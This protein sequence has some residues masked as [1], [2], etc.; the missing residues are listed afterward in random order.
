MEIE[1][2]E[3]NTLTLNTLRE[4]EAHMLNDPAGIFVNIYIADNGN[5]LIV[6]KTATSFRCLFGCIIYNEDDRLK[7]PR[8]LTFDTFGN[9][10]FI[11]IG[12]SKIRKYLLSNNICSKYRLHIA[13]E[14]SF[15]VTLQNCFLS[16]DFTENKQINK[17]F[18]STI[19]TLTESRYTSKLTT[20]SSTYIK[21]CRYPMYYYE[22]MQIRVVKEGNYN[23][24]VNS[25]V[26]VYVNLYK[27]HFK[28]IEPDFN[29]FVHAHV[30]CDISQIKFVAF[31]QPNETHE[32]LVATSSFNSITSFS[33]VINGP[34]SVSFSRKSIQYHSIF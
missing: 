5:Y 1:S 19:P 14:E 16:L 12:T 17:T 32:L 3:L 31:L 30:N 2:F 10:Y 25:S 27:N 15:V 28:P 11:D 21:S 29:L 34:S 7:I 4:S 18:T 22:G 33:V 26:E 9:I 6:V 24:F 23:I 20:D 13:T 8:A